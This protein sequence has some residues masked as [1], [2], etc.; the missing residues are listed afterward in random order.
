MARQPGRKLKVDELIRLTPG[1]T[2][3]RVVRVNDCA[4]YLKR[5][6]A[7]GKVVTLKD[8]TFTVWEEGNVLA[9][10]PY[11]VVERVDQGAELELPQGLTPPE[12][13]GGVCS[14]CERGTP[15]SSQTIC[16]RCSDEMRLDS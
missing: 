5:R 10:S 11:S 3:Y 14:E 12:E 16:D 8:R 1:G 9:V 7:E 4:A 2:V 6:N 15:H 13:E